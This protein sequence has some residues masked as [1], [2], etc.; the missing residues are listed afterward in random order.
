[1]WK[2]KLQLRSLKRKSSFQRYYLK[3]SNWMLMYQWIETS[4]DSTTW[5]I[6]D[7]LWR[8]N[9]TLMAQTKMKEHI[10]MSNSLMYQAVA[11]P[12]LLMHFPSKRSKI[13]IVSKKSNLHYITTKDGSGY[14]F[15]GFA[16]PSITTI[17][18]LQNSR[19]K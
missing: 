6:S 12:I 16:S 1:L 5:R 8:S 3:Y 18:L 19:K 9:R 10:L 2:E 7:N 14:N 17:Q 15:H 11:I 13:T 4:L